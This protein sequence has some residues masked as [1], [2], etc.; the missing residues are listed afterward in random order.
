[1]N[2]TFRNPRA[3]LAAF[4]LLLTLFVIP[5]GAQTLPA[6]P[7][8]A[9]KSWLLL[10][11]GSGQMLTTHAIDERIDPASLT[12]LM[13][14]YL[15]FSALHQ[16][17]LSLEQT[18]A[19]SER[20]WKQEGSRMFIDPRQRPRVQEL[21]QGMI[22]QS[23][24]DACV[25]LAEAIAGSEEKFAEM[26]TREAQR[27]GMKATSFRNS[28]GLTDPQHYTTAR[29]LALL[30]SAMIRDFPEEYARYYSMKEYRYNNI[31][32]PNR[33]RLLYAD[34]S[35]DGMKT[36]F[37]EA[38]GYC[39]IASSKRGPRRLISVVLGTASDNARAVESQKLLEWGYQAFDAVRLYEKNQPLAQLRIYK[40]AETQLPIGFAHDLVLAVPKGQAD[41]I[42]VDLVA[43]SLV[44]PIAQGARVGTVRVNVAGTPYGEFPAVALKPMPL[45][46][47][48]G[49]IPD[50]VRLW[51]Q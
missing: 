31:T 30:A 48:L 22:V 43:Q 23:G 16:K 50:T 18:V 1:M 42:K 4:S 17:T 37:T 44:A 27:L 10:E 45:A 38:A 40:G 19:V 3:L 47:F 2:A 12:K 32:Q 9:A 15:S 20:A 5:A 25:A 49:R 28:T 8:L 13:T 36:G 14:A 11:F 51:L 39:L 33:N 29:D 26:M 6:P 35:V 21:I 46:G 34:P 7:T 41:Q 24:N